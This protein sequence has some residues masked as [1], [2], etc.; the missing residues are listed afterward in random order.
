MRTKSL[1]V[2]IVLLA[3]LALSACAPAA[4]SAR[5]LNVNGVGQVFITPDIAYL[6]AGVH[7]EKPTAAEAVAANNAQTQQVIDA[8]K[9]F[10]VEE[11]DIHTSS[12]SIWPIDRYDPA[13]GTPTG[14]KYYSVDN[15]IYIT[16]RD[17]TK[18]GALLDTV[19]KAG[20]NT[21]NSVQF[22]LSDKTAAMKEARAAAMK[23]A[24]S[25]AEELAGLASVSLVEITNISYTD[26]TPYVYAE[27]GRGGGG[28][29][30]IQANV[31]IEPGQMTITASVSVTYEIK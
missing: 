25:Q 1:L 26:S 14:E 16:A 4:S 30:G 10:G 20:A 13:T 15:T 2:S 18:L 24:K 21:I 7:T 29:G 28:G 27:M 8:L 3:A 9:A 31:P 17:L 6:Y 22:D 5:T 12:F 11:K 23:N 19:I